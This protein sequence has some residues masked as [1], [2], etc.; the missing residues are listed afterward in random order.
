VKGL[1]LDEHHFLNSPFLGPKKP[2]LSDASLDIHTIDDIDVGNPLAN[3]FNTVNDSL[4]S[5]FLLFLL[6]YPLN[7]SSPSSSTAMIH[8][9]ASCC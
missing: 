9:P 6:L 7:S 5:L 1:S 8:L 3:L 4:L 2:P